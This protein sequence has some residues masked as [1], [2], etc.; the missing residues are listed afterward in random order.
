MK[1]SE[2]KVELNNNHKASIY[3]VFVLVSYLNFIIGV[4]IVKQKRMLL[5]IKSI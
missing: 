3:V 5:V 2:L 1:S 4:I